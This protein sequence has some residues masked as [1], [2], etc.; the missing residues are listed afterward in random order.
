LSSTCSDAAVT[1]CFRPDDA[2]GHIC[3]SSAA[4]L[5]SNN[6]GNLVTT[7]CSISPAGLGAISAGWPRTSIPCAA[8]SAVVN[9][10]RISAGN[11]VARSL[12]LG[13]SRAPRDLAS[14]VCIAI[15][16]P[17]LNNARATVVGFR[18][19][20]ASA[21]SAHANHDVRAPICDF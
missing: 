14:G 8:T 10:D 18:G 20:A 3:I 9:A 1:P 2:E 5:A 17:I 7:C 21:R 4:G 15:R 6:V 19:S 13:I 16:G 12:A 11:R